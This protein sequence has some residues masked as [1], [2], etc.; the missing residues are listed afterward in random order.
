MSAGIHAC[1]SKS[2]SGH[3]WP[4]MIKAIIHDRQIQ[5]ATIRGCTTQ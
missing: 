2:K 4:R 1:K 3:P 5:K